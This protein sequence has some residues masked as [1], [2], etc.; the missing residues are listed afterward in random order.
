MTFEHVLSE[1]KLLL[2]NVLRDTDAAPSVND[3]D[4]VVN[5]LGLDSIQMVAFLLEVEQRFDVQL[6][7]ES[8]DIAKLGSVKEFAR[9]VD[10]L[11]APAARS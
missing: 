2:A 7:F 6:D 11:R 8:L 9:F 3:E 4:D 5:D 10:G 1:V